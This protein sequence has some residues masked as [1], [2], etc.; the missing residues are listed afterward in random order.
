ME[1]ITSSILLG[2]AGNL[3]TNVVQSNIGKLQE[4]KA[5]KALSKAGI[6]SPS[7]NQIIES[8]IK[9]STINFLNNNPSYNISEIHSFLSSRTLGKSIA[10]FI[11]NLDPID[12]TALA[13][14]MSH[15]VGVPLKDAPQ[16]WP[17]Q[18]DPLRFI[19]TF[20]E[21]LKSTFGAN[22]DGGLIWISLKITEQ[23]SHILHI[24][25]A[26]DEINENVALIA[27][28]APQKRD[29]TEFEELYL[30]H[31]NKRFEKV[32]TPGAR[33]LHGVT[34]SLSIAYISLNLKRGAGGDA[35]RAEQFLSQNPM[36][37]IRGPAGSGKTTLLS[38]IVT[39][40][41]QQIGVQNADNP[42]KGL[43]PFFVPL[44][45]VARLESGPPS[46]EKLV[47]YSVD[48]KV[49]TRPM[50]T[51][52]LDG[53]LR[54]QRA[55]VMIDGV[56]ELPASRRASFWTWLQSLLSEYPG[57]RI[58]VTSRALPGSATPGI[59]T[60]QWNPPAAFV[61]AQL[62]DMSNADV[63]QFVH[64]WHDAVDSSKLDQAEKS[65]L[66][67][68]RQKLPL[69]LEDPAN[70]R[71]RELCNTPLLCAMVCVL[72][73]REEGYL[74]RYRVELYDK[75]CEML[76]EARDLKRE[77]APPTGPLASLSKNDKEMVL[78]RLAIEMMHNRQD[79]DIISD[80][81]YRIEISREKAI[82]WIGPK[83]ASFQ[84]PLARE[85]SAEQILDFL[86]ERTGLLREP[87]TD[88]ID[89]PHRT[90]QEYLAACAAGADSQED[91]LAK[92]VDDDQW[93]ETIMLAAGTTTGGVA[94]GRNLIEALINRGER[95]KSPR[96]R[97]QHIRK[98]CFAL[99]L[100][101]LENLKQQEPILR[102]RVLS[103]LGELVPPRN[104]VDAGILSVAGDAAVPY[105]AYANF[106]DENTA[107]VAACARSLR[108]IGTTEAMK[109]LERGY[110]TDHREAVVAEI[111]K[112]GQFEY[113]LIPTIDNYVRQYGHLPHYA[114]AENLKT[115]ANMDRLTQLSLH[116]PDTK[117]ISHL[118][119]LPNLSK[120]I[121]E[122]L[123]DTEHDISRIFKNI[124]ELTISHPSI[125]SFDWLQNMESLRSFVLLDPLE[126]AN[127][128][129][130][131]F[132]KSI[133]AVS[134]V[135]ASPQTIMMLDDLKD[136][137]QISI[138]SASEY[139]DFSFF[140][141]MRSLTHI[142][143][144]EIFHACDLSSLSDVTSAESI[145]LFSISELTAPPK[146]T[147]PNLKTLQ[148]ANISGTMDVN[149]FSQAIN[150]EKLHIV[151]CRD[152][153]EYNGLN[154][155]SSLRQLQLG[156]LQIDSPIHFNSFEKLESL[157]LAYIP[158]LRDQWFEGV[159]RNLKKIHID[160]CPNIT[161]LN[162]LSNCS[163]LESISIS[164]LQKI[165][166]LSFLSNMNNI[167]SIRINDCDNI[168]DLDPLY[169]SN[170]EE[171]IIYSMS[172][173]KSFD[174]IKS[175]TKLKTIGVYE[176]E[177]L[178][179]LSILENLPNLEKIIL[180]PQSNRMHIPESLL[181]K[182]AEVPPYASLWQLR[183][184]DWLHDIWVY[185]HEFER[186]R[187]F[188]RPYY[189]HPRF[190][191]HIVGQ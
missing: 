33:E 64:H 71:I 96:R 35:L 154:G 173:I 148:L 9:K 172:G 54:S 1:P 15:Y 122:R 120:L 69:K 95:H 146:L 176:C 85:A 171:M 3:A 36:V 170:V 174:A 135:G 138:N 127:I 40:C 101:C 23:H 68:A 98:T 178:N 158:Q 16:A 179:D 136:L 38:W 97:Q 159:S 152:L 110:L 185:D 142:I 44:R 65:S 45:K 28:S 123:S 70:R 73:W 134:L 59:L 191:R 139:T 141:K 177:H 77:I 55:I 91:M 63:T 57:N 130:L 5:G 66:L 181:P 131:H 11:L 157:H 84:H 147:S 137:K 50:P 117:N 153:T 7:F 74:P 52:W 47:E 169:G 119:T 30:K 10:S 121:I 128:T 75:C 14:R 29:V 162:A 92:K 102:E 22:A 155:L 49:W 39:Q 118:E 150:L 26:V 93:H 41:A 42:W 32:T 129:P 100:G 8:A 80:E 4:T 104:D 145:Y 87:A 165:D 109:A 72:H 51:A 82:K 27:N 83:I 125:S 18:I 115:V 111:C 46:V 62:Q 58:I 133:E 89:F 19:S 160:R 34:Q 2:I 25:R 167:N 164:S 144:E 124:K 143:L 163:M 151:S 132:V 126:D 21:E 20:V 37:A 6:L 116:W 99:A 189:W 78:Q 94:F 90:F 166:D 76:I 48:E 24:H 106:K 188:H 105:L 113:S 88:L 56:D 67:E 107:T 81:T 114:P 168:T 112:S 79:G 183:D 184:N 103:N 31:L 175:W 13:E 186:V 156:N 12:V 61:E 17:N 190:G 182:V 149:S 187:R 180:N 161:S 140:N 53:V 43:I 108:L 60:E 86:V